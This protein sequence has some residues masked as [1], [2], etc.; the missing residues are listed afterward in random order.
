MATVLKSNSLATGI[1]TTQAE[2][3]NWEDVA[4]RAKDYLETIRTQAKAMLGACTKECEQLREK[5]RKEGMS[6]G[7]SHVERLATT[8]ANQMA[9]DKIQSSAAAI[10]QICNELESATTQWLRE[11]QHET[12]AIAIGIAEKLMIRQMEKD[13]SI[14]L[15][16]I[17][18]SVR[19][20]HGQKKIMLRLH[21]EDAMILSSA[22]PDLLEQVSPGIEIQVIDDASVGRCGV[23]IQTADTTIDRTI[24]SQLKR[25]E[26]ELG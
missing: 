25:L 24:A 17:E 11:W 3:F 21:S 23:I 18:D 10:T 19:L 9:T 8:I 20:L 1:N 4:G 26:Q 22:L 12:V 15:K 5:A 14:L 13:P 2:V 6:A 16:W 7:E